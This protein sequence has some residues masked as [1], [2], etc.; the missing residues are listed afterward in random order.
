MIREVPRILRK[1][2]FKWQANN[3]KIYKPNETGN[4]GAKPLDITCSYT[5]NP[6]WL[7]LSTTEVKEENSSTK[8]KSPGKLRQVRELAG[9]TQ[10]AIQLFPKSFARYALIV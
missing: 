4:L 5:H 8:W 7:E 3:Q 1:L 9:D 10:A 6:F 2:P